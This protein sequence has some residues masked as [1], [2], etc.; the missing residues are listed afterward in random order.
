MDIPKWPKGLPHPTSWL[1]TIALTVTYGCTSNFLAKLMPMS[2]AGIT[3]WLFGSWA[4]SAACMTA[5][6]HCLTG[7]FFWAATW[8]PQSFPKY[9]ELH[10]KVAITK[11]AKAWDKPNWDSLREGINALIASLVAAIIAL[12]CLVYLFYAAAPEEIE[13]SQIDKAVT[14]QVLNTIAALISAAFT[15]AKFNQSITEV[16]SQ[17]FEPLINVWFIVFCLWIGSV[18]LL[19]QCDLWSRLH[20]AEKLAKK[21]EKA[22]KRKAPKKK[23]SSKSKKPQPPLDLIEVELNQI[24]G[25][26]GATVMRPVRKTATSQ[27]V[28]WEVFRSGPVGPYTKEQLRS[29]Q[30]IT[31]KTNV[32]RVGEND[33]TRAGE[34]PELADFLSSKS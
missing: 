29:Q 19:Y 1:R 22:A 17:D 24:K 2:G 6:H 7:L 13:E 3:F 8:Y 31:A 12:T 26:M 16:L 10:Q 21:A 25:E 5:Y 32:R 33:W 27:Q 18:V 9:Q 11:P 30:K 23:S 15:G 20:R 28:L 34:I 4:G 14:Y